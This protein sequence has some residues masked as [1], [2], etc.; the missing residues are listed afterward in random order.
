MKYL[1]RISLFV[2]FLLIY[3]LYGSVYAVYYD[4]A[5]NTYVYNTS[6]EMTQDNNGDGASITGST[7]GTGDEVVSWTG[8]E[9]AEVSSIPVEAINFSGPLEY[10][11]TELADHE[12]TILKSLQDQYDE[13]RLEFED[14]TGGVTR[15]ET[16][17][18]LWLIK[19]QENLNESL[20]TAYEK[21]RKD[22]KAMSADLHNNIDALESKITQK[23]LDEL[24]ETLEIAALQNKVDAY[25]SEYTNMVNM[26]AELMNVEIT[27]ADAMLADVSETG[28]ELLAEYDARVKTYEDLQEYYDD[29]I[30]K[31]SFAGALVWPNFLDV[32]SLVDAL[33]SYYTSLFAQKW[34]ASVLVYLPR[35]GAGR[36]MAEDEYTLALDVFENQLDEEIN[37]L[38]GDL[39]PIKDLQLINKSIINLRS[40]YVDKNGVYDCKAFSEN[41]TIDL[42][43][44]A[45]KEQMQ[46]LLRKLENAA[47]QVAVDG[48]L[49]TNMNDLKK[50]L[51]EGWA[52]TMKNIVEEVSQRY[53]KTLKEKLADKSISMLSY[54]VLSDADK[55]EKTVRKFLQAK[56]YEWLENDKIDLFIEKLKQANNKL[57]TL[58]PKAKGKA[59]KMLQVIEKVIGEFL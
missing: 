51:L 2:V 48:K 4:A 37:T 52:K 33:K 47:N 28:K 36:K 32:A 31:S 58:L 26:F 39:Y 43:A 49:P 34:F 42:A 45:L 41:K 23:L 55:R 9:N 12:K 15:L 27:D 7:V 54:A 5:T 57:D 16:L 8:N 10:L 17:Q 24:P 40:A 50:G 44:P 22:I 53:Q 30:K 18:C 20:K 59:K 21:L 6:N 14:L 11:H 29:F 25:L 3:A 1:G 38:I 46:K 19:D 35:Y 56:Y 13:F